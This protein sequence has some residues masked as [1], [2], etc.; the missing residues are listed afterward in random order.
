M[1]GYRMVPDRVVRQA[2]KPP[3]DEKGLPPI[4]EMV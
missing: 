2:S 3:S 4:Q 1:K